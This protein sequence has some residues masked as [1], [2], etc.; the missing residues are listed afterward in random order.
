[1]VDPFRQ[2]NAKRVIWSY[3]GTG[4]SRI[5]RVYVNSEQMRCITNIQYIPTGLHEHRLLSFSKL[6]GIDLGK[7]YYKLNTKI[8]TDPKY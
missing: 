3:V 1:M 2:Q 6:P 7:G 4:K 5:D 8:L